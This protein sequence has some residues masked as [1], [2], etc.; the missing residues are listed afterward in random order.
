MKG[1]EVARALVVKV[2]SSGNLH[3]KPGKR[4]LSSR[5]NLA[6][7]LG[8][9]VNKRDDDLQLGRAR[10]WKVYQSF[11]QVSCCSNA[12]RQGAGAQELANIKLAP[13]GP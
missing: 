7:I 12:L 6:A 3:C 2:D 8:H 5:R 1:Q 4:L 9:R 13:I 10:P 11:T